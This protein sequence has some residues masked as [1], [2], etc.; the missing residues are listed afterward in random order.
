M[1]TQEEVDELLVKTEELVD[2]VVDC[3]TACVALR[4]IKKCQALEDQF[5]IPFVVITWE[6]WCLTYIPDEILQRRFGYGR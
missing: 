3:R 1:W 5:F 4:Y 6:D 2:K